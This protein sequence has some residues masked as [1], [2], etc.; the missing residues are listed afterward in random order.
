MGVDSWRSAGAIR[1]SFGANITE[2]EITAACQRISQV[3]Q[4]L[5]DSCLVIT[6][7]ADNLSGQDLDGLIQLKN[8]SNCTWLL[9]DSKSRRS[10]R[11]RSV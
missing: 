11:D 10:Y 6:G 4:A 2:S 1:L 7:D 3:G 8:G 9:M 5:T